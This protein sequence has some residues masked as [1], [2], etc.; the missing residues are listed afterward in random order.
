MVP[1]GNIRMR[2]EYTEVLVQTKI[3]LPCY[4]LWADKSN[5]LFFNI[6]QIQKISIQTNRIYL[7]KKMDTRAHLSL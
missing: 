7:V 6:C 2:S 5:N 4:F 3:V 1:I